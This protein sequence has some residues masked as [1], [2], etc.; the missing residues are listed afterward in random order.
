MTELE[1]IAKLEKQLKARKRKALA[2]E[3]EKLGRKFYK[4]SHA[5]SMSAA[6]NILAHI[7]LSSHQVSTLTTEQF[8]QLQTIADSMQW[9]GNFWKID[10]LPE[11]SEW[12]SQFRTTHAKGEDDEV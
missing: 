8:T 4:Q 1:R 9:N 6:E 5:Q 10:N 12:L 11:V 7:P 2:K 3:Y